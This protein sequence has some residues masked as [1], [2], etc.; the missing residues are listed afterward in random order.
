MLKV[1]IRLKCEVACG[2]CG[3]D[4]KGW[5][6]LDRGLTVCDSGGFLLAGMDQVSAVCD[7]CCKRDGLPGDEV[8]TPA[9]LFRAVEPIV[10]AL[11]G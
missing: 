2:R 10:K 11:E 8:V 9:A 7:A 1:A 3:K 4:V 6:D 5:V